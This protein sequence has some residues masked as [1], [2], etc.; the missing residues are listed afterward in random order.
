MRSSYPWKGEK[1]FNCHTRRGAKGSKRYGEEEGERL[2]SLKAAE[3][4][5][6]Y[7]SWE[8]AMRGEAVQ[9]TT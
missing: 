3:T 8:A 9:A 6:L 2:I 4:I 5:V 7:V 1:P